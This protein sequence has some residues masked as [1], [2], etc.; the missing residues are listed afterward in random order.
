MER[1]Y[2]VYIPVVADVIFDFAVVVEYGRARYVRAPLGARESLYY[3]MRFFCF[4][5]YGSARFRNE[6]F[7]T[8]CLTGTPICSARFM[9][10]STSYALLTRIVTRFLSDICIASGEFSRNAVSMLFLRESSSL[11]VF[12]ISVSSVFSAGEMSFCFKIGSSFQKKNAEKMPKNNR[13][14]Y[15]KRQKHKKSVR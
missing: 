8:S 14:N 15:K 4:L 3:R 7:S 10:V 6:I 2:L 12:K 11:R 1:I 5:Y 9:P 13:N